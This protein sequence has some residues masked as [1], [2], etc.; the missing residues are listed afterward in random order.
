MLADIAST[1]RQ[2]HALFCGPLLHQLVMLLLVG[3]A[4]TEGFEATD[5]RL[6]FNAF[7]RGHELPTPGIVFAGTPRT[8]SLDSHCCRE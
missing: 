6:V 8:A 1:R 5:T 2:G 7:L 4:F 3:S